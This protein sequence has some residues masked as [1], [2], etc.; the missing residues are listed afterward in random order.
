MTIKMAPDKFI[1]F[2]FACRMHVLKFVNRLEFNDVQTVRKYAVWFPFKQV[3]AFICCDVRNGC[4]HI[5]AMCC[6]TFYAVSVINS[7]FSG[8]VV[9]IKILQIV[10]EIN[11]AGTEIAA[12]Q[13]CVCRKY[14]SDVDMSLTA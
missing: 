7:S 5:S 8:F 11:G 14:G 1:D 12:E 6:R 3:F 2:G 4:E 10:I 13:R 9:D